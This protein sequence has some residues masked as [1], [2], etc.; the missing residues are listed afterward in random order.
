MQSNDALFL[1]EKL[2]SVFQSERNSFLDA[3]HNITGEHQSFA[4]KDY[5]FV[6]TYLRN[7][8]EIYSQS[9]RSNQKAK[10][11]VFLILS[12]NEP[13]TMSVIPVLNALAAGNTVYVRPSSR[14]VSFFTHLWT[15]VEVESLTKNY[16]N[17]VHVKESEV[18]EIFKLIPSM[19][20]VFFSEVIRTP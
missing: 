15:H 5:N 1:A 2:L 7:Y 4:Q 20:A 8:K 12:F 17:I 13:F 14:C 9:K 19:H 6:V 11:K 18:S 3:Y 10:G 16:L